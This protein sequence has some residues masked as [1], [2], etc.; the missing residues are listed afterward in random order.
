[1]LVYHVIELS[2]SACDALDQTVNV[3]VTDCAFLGPE[4]VIVDA[5][6]WGRNHWLRYAGSWLF[7]PK[8]PN[9]DASRAMGK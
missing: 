5:L 8:F 4:Q 3:M 1:M 2:Q 6:C 7:V 9:Q